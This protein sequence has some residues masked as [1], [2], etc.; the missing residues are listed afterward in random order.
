MFLPTG[1]QEEIPSMRRASAEGPLEA[2]W[3]EEE[4]LTT[5]EA[6]WEVSQEFR[7]QLTLS[8]LRTEEMSQ[9]DP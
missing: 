6:I 7:E 3:G 4:I 2:R 1:S 9:N 8:A 5:G